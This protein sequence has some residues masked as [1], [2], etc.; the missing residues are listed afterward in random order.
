M[1]RAKPDNNNII[2]EGDDVERRA[3][4]CFASQETPACLSREFNKMPLP[5][6][7]QV[8]HDVFGIPTSSFEIPDNALEEMQ[9]ELSLLGNNNEKKTSA[10][11]LALEL[12]S[13]Y[14]TSPKLLISFL[15]A[16]EGQPKRAATRMVRHFET[17]LDL[18]GRDKLVKDIEISDLD[19][20]DM[21][22]LRSGGFQVLP[23]K[24][25]AGRPILFGRY[26]CMKYRQAKN[27]VSGTLA[28]HLRTLK[29]CGLCILIFIQHFRAW[30]TIAPPLCFIAYLVARLMVYL[31]Q[32]CR[33]RRPSKVW[34]YFHWL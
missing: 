20:Y 5:S 34:H 32:Y 16:V 4:F 18:F 8:G 9:Q 17:K 31:E 10:Y 12:D 14:A 3:A 33:G 11:E 23:K 29:P 24:D 22:A 21:E 27:M 28:L 26:T 13:D 15:R 30:L 2:D 7:E 6:R 1:K 25:R 19:E